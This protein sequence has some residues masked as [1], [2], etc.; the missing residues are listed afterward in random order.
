MAAANELLVV[1]G[2]Q[3]TRALQELGMKDHLH[4]INATQI[5][6]FSKN[7]TQT[8]RTICLHIYLDTI[9]SIVEQVA[10]AERVQDGILGVVDD[11]VRANG[12]QCLSHRREDA[13]LELDDVRVV[14]DGCLF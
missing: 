1:H 5:E 14:Q 10:R 12:R 9:R 7:Q 13:L 3:R 6:S 2:E 8:K 11:V 4:L